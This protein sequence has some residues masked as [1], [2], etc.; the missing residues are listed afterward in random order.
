MFEP[1]LHGAG[2]GVDD[3]LDAFDTQLREKYPSE[4]T[5][6]EGP[7]AEAAAE[8]LEHL[9]PPVFMPGTSDE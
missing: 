8:M 3:V 4:E 5:W 7:E 1:G 9:M 2:Q 6:G